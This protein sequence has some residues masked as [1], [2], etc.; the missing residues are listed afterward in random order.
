M[1]GGSIT[2]RQVTTATL[3]AATYNQ[4]SKLKRLSKG[5]NSKLKMSLTEKK[6][7]QMCSTPCGGQES[8]PTKP[9]IYIFL[10]NLLRRQASPVRQLHSV[11]NSRN[12]D[13]GSTNKAP[14]VYLYVCKYATGEKK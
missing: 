3:T 13:W 9:H 11:V 6:K 1:L 12:S 5:T 8:L 10:S 7:I 14:H 2:H 4:I